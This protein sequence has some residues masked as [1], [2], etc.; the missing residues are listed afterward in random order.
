M[1][2]V[3]IFS[4]VS[5]EFVDRR[6][7]H[8]SIEPQPSV[9]DSCAG[10]AFSN[11]RRPLVE[12]PV[13]LPP[14][15]QNRDDLQGFRLGTVDDQVRIHGEESHVRMSVRSLRWWPALGLRSQKGN[16]LPND[17]FHAI[18]HFHAALCS[19]VM[20]DRGQILYCLGR[21]DVDATSSRLSF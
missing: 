18:R 10:W 14:T 21:Q 17:G 9:C 20:P 7:V 16:P 5:A 11:S 1:V 6:G 15:V 3:N 13:N 2:R 19:D 4:A 8:Q 12:N